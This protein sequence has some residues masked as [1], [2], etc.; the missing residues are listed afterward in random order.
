MLV[1][2]SKYQTAGVH[3]RIV[4]MK[5]VTLSCQFPHRMNEEN[6]GFT[7]IFFLPPS[8][9]NSIFMALTILVILLLPLFFSSFSFS[10]I[11]IYP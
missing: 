10:F 3:S 9:G 11:L 4:Q 7:N 5:Q 8:L 6:S 2:S 1:K